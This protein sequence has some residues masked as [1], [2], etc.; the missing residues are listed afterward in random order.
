MKRLKVPP[1]RSAL[2]LLGRQVKFLTQGHDM[3]EKKRELLTRVVYDRLREYRRMRREAETRL[4]EVY[5]WLAVCQLRM[6]SHM[7]RQASLGL[8]LSVEVEIVPRSS[9]GVEYPS[10]RARTLPLQPVGLMWTDASFDEARAR[11][12]ELIAFLARLGEAE[13]AL[14]R[15][16][17]EQRKTQK[18]VNALKYNIIPRY[19]N[20]VR[21]IRSA[22][23]EEER[24]SLFRIKRM[25]ERA[26]E[27]T[28]P[29]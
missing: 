22:L 11:M 20:T 6:G 25:R 1:T 28:N 27:T 9:V 21:Y 29:A 14:R 19:R 10:V 2:L 15:F 8:T 16:V 12:T 18:R 26:R 5:H 3:L 24:E 7:L 17:V 23:E 13:N 4:Q